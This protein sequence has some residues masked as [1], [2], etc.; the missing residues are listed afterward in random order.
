[1][2]E[3]KYKY[4][5]QLKLYKLMSMVIRIDLCYASRPLR[6]LQYALQAAV[7]PLT[8]RKQKYN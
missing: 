1:M 4:I 5:F 2:G 6:W 8:Y 3:W 7:P